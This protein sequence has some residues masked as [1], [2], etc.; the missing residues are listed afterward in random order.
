MYLSACLVEPFSSILR[1]YSNIITHFFNLRNKINGIFSFFLSPTYTKP[2][3]FE[4]YV[5]R[6]I[7]PQVFSVSEQSTYPLRRNTGGLFM[8]CCFSGNITLWIL[9]AL[10]VLGSKDG[11]FCSNV[12]SGCG[13]PIL[14][15]LLYCL[16]KNGTLSAILTP[17]CQCGCN[18]NCN[19]NC[20]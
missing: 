2:R 9:I 13:L 17:S 8:N 7:K 3:F 5:S 18:C 16:Y 11:M 1:E 15:A 20:R 6:K 19:C 4:Y 12:F 10:I 14:I